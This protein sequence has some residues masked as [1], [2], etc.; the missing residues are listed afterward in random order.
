V[1]G[2]VHCHASCHRSPHGTGA[3]RAPPTRNQRLSPAGC[4]GRVRSFCLISV[5]SVVQLYPGPSGNVKPRNV[6]S[7]RGSSVVPDRRVHHVR[8]S[9]TNRAGSCGHRPAP[10]QNASIA[11]EQKP[12]AHRRRSPIQARQS[13]GGGL[14]RSLP[15][16]EAIKRGRRRPW[17]PPDE[18]SARS[19]RS[20][21][22]LRFH[23]R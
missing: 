8:R 5:R 4:P 7:L 22:W 17:L 21:S 19:S 20:C 6:F 23:G 18:H 13:A 3:R 10:S 12:V 11:T 15:G 1:R 14:G 9:L 16:G 2:S